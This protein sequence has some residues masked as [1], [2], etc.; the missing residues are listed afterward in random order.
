MLVL[1]RKR[2]ESIRISDDIVV[3]VLEI[4]RNKVRLGIDALKEIPVL[5]TELQKQI[6]ESH[7]RPSVQKQLEMYDKMAG[8]LDGQP[9]LSS[10]D[11]KW[12]S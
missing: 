8:D 2:Q 10:F 4:R 9:L 11:R 3:T 12:I 6:L 7:E 5:R 1:S